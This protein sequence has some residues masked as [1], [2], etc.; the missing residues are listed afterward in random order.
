[1]AASASISLATSGTVIPGVAGFSIVVIACA[2]VAR[3][4]TDVKFQS[5]TTD[6]IGAIPLAANAG[7]VLPLS[8]V[9]YPWMKCAQGESLNLNL[10]SPV[11]VGGVVTYDLV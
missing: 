8:S 9:Q 3:A 5:A 2:L 6:L 11:D 1:M 7:F 10:T 4:A